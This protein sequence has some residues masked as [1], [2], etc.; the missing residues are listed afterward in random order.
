[1]TESFEELSSIFLDNTALPRN[2]NRIISMDYGSSD[3]YSYFS[4][5]SGNMTY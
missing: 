3:D 5:S 1:M 2:M 4:P